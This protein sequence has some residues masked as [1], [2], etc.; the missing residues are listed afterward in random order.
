MHKPLGTEKHKLVLFQVFSSR[1]AHRVDLQPVPWS[2]SQSIQLPS[3]EL[4]THKT[5]QFFSWPY[6][7]VKTEGIALVAAHKTHVLTFLNS[8]NAAPKAGFT[9][10]LSL[11]HCGSLLKMAGRAYLWSRSRM[12]AKS[13]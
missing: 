13:F 10:V 9:W 5:R 2:T 1:V 4:E 12:L 8:A 11:I 6:S 3:M 7:K